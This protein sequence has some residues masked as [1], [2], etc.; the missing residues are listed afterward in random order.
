MDV[1]EAGFDSVDRTEQSRA[2]SNGGIV[3]TGVKFWVPTK[4]N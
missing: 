3:V 2:R 1:I 4:G